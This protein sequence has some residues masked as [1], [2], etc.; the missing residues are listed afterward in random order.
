MP[1][2]GNLTVQHGEADGV[3][4]PVVACHN[5]TFIFTEEY[6]SILKSVGIH[7]GALASREIAWHFLSHHITPNT[8][9]LF[10]SSEPI[11]FEQAKAMFALF[12]RVYSEQ[13]CGRCL[14][15]D[16]HIAPLESQAA[17]NRWLYYMFKPMDYVTGYVRLAN[18]GADIA[19][20]N[21]D[22]DH[23]LF[24][25][26]EV[27]MSVRSP[28]RFGNLFCNSPGYI[29]AGSIT[30][31]RKEQKAKRAALKQKRQP[32]KESTAEK[33]LRDEVLRRNEEVRGDAAGSG[34][35][36]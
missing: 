30:A 6:V 5:A 7:A 35:K 22:L 25:N 27:I 33:V 19:K 4:N 2:A 36:G 20:L 3:D 31:W 16:L 13:P 34:A 24:Q 28:R 8:H 32:Q 11:E 26:A 14:Y 18:G 15:P 23:H 9:D 12:E 17:V 10:N 29:G 21:A 1:R